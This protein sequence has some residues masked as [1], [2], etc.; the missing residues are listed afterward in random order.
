MSLDF[1]KHKSVMLKVLKDIFTD[2]A[3]APYLGFKGG[4]AAMLLHGLP[5]HS[6]D[7]DFD[8]LDLD[9]EELIFTRMQQIVNRYGNI[10]EAVIKRNNILIVVS[11]GVGLP[12]LKVD[13]NRQQFGSQYEYKNV[14][15]IPMQ[16]MV[17]PDMFAHKLMA[18]YERIGKTSRDIFDVRFFAESGWDVNKEMV[19]RRSG[20]SFADTVAECITALQKIPD[21]HILDGLG[22]LLDE[23]QKDSVRAK[24]KDDTTFLLKLLMQ[25]DNQAG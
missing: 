21:A 7:L 25:Q 20:K 8:I 15:G 22:E 4:T 2:T 16:V 6:V 10:T 12:Q 23:P 17:R 24:L 5:R 3:I 9:K 14:L 19:E 11:Y 13:I 18:M 1:E